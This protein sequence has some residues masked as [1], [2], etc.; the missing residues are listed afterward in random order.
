MALRNYSEST[1]IWFPSPSSRADGVMMVFRP[2]RIW[3][4][5]R[6]AAR[7]SS[8]HTNGTGWDEDA[9]DASLVTAGSNSRYDDRGGADAARVRMGLISEIGTR[10]WIV[11]FRSESF[12]LPSH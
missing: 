12:D 9:P 11:S 8:S 5:L 10:S 4:L 7:T 2:M 1:N 6:I 3:E